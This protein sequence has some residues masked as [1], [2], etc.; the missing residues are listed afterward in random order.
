MC[1]QNIRYAVPLIVIGAYFTGWAVQNLMHDNAKKSQRLCG[2]LICGFITLY[3][4]S[5]FAVFDIV[6]F[7]MTMR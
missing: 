6:F 1:T 4:V 5:G 2:S 7:D 3:A